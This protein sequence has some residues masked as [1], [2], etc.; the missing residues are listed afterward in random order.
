M[1]H[2]RLASL[3]AN[4]VIAYNNMYLKS[5]A[6]RIFKPIGST[7]YL[8]ERNGGARVILN[9]MAYFEDITT[10]ESRSAS[11]NALPSISITTHIFTALEDL[12][13]YNASIS[14]PP[15]RSARIA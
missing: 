12:L 7:D 9:S 6:G 2:S 13:V 14:L 1:D 3:R 10:E 15:T 5:E 11:I 8:N 4:R